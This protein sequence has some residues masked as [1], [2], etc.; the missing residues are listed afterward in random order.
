ML[1]RRYRY[2]V[3]V[4][5]TFVSASVDE[6][7]LVSDVLKS[8]REDVKKFVECHKEGKK[9]A[10]GSSAP[11]A[12][13]GGRK[14]SE[15]VE[16]K[17]FTIT[18]L[19]KDPEKHRPVSEEDYVSKQ[20]HDDCVMYSDAYGEVISAMF[21]FKRGPDARPTSK[22]RTRFEYTDDEIRIMERI[23]KI[24]R[25]ARK[26]S[27]ATTSESANAANIAKSLMEKYQLELKDLEDV[28]SCVG[29]KRP[30]PSHVSDDTG[31]MHRIFLGIIEQKHL[32]WVEK[33][34][35]AISMYFDVATF[36][37]AFTG[38]FVFYGHSGLTIAALRCFHSLYWDIRFMG[39][40]AMERL[41]W[42]TFKSQ[43]KIKHYLEYMETSVIQYYVGIMEQLETDTINPVIEARNAYAPT[44]NNLTQSGHA[45][46]QRV[47]EARG[48][49]IHKKQTVPVLD[50]TSK[51]YLQ[52]KTDAAKVNLTSK[53]KTGTKKL[54]E[55]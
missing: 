25:L 36:K 38:C 13:K 39:E 19:Y 18:H 8:L 11:A 53:V 28:K 27:G 1:L 42:G 29:A 35:V 41:N 46:A 24:Q 22:K 44:V 14:S 6:F 33:M 7:Q 47:L 4:G 17:G 34:A 43:K 10:Q 21:C 15:V 32:F 51:M 49:S 50:T 54:K 20:C 9:Y 12:T 5:D 31:S 30:R 45:I 3:V 48:V 52:G 26:G 37:D 16:K 2:L 40:R 23:T 55:N